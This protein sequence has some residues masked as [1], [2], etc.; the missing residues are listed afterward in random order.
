MS[1]LKQGIFN[2]I[3][4]G[5][6][7]LIGGN[8]TKRGFQYSTG[9]QG[10]CKLRWKIS[11]TVKQVKHNP[12]LG[13]SCK[14][15]RYIKPTLIEVPVSATTPQLS[16]W[17]EANLNSICE[18]FRGISVTPVI[19]QAFERAVN[20][21]N[22]FAYR[23]G[24]S[25]TNAF[26]KMQHTKCFKNCF[27]IRL[28]LNYN[29]AIWFYFNC[30][31]KFHFNFNKDYY[32]YCYHYYYFLFY[33]WKVPSVTWRESSIKNKLTSS[34]TAKY[35]NHIWRSFITTTKHQRKSHK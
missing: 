10:S 27:V 28:C 30:N 31:V 2:W 25:C 4:K 13:H 11:R 19:E 3:I 29:L 24:G 14:D 33:G 9:G 7:A 22:Q 17:Q 5:C 34:V 32:Y 1:Q 20:I 6:K 8:G 26:I 18:D 35:L 23:T 12:N 15:E 16:T 21:F